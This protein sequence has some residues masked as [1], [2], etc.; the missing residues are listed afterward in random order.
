MQEK[1]KFLETLGAIV[2]IAKTQD[3]ILTQEEIQE[4]FKGA[5]LTKNQM[6]AI[7][8]YLA[9]NK[10]RVKGFFYASKEEREEPE[11]SQGEDTRQKDSIYLKM[12]LEDLSFI[13]PELPGETERLY[14]RMRGGEETARERL[15]NV[16]LKKVVDLARD[17]QNQGV[18]LE[19]LVQEGNIG[20]LSGLENL[21]KIQE[22]LDAEEYLK[23]AVCQSMEN[24]I[25]DSMEEDDLEN[26]ILARANLISQAAR[27]LEEDLGRPATLQELSEYTKIP[28]EE[29]D[30]L[31]K[32]QG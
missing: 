1:E 20:L 23:E 16:W 13:E 30:G 29:M 24:L 3:G 22:H 7:Y 18:F 25:D 14:L 2:E 10:I 12:Y 19:D 32:L 6:D 4:Y 21:L 27:A 17:Y 26:I 9:E 11:V 8:A 5:D 28:L 15:V 31:L